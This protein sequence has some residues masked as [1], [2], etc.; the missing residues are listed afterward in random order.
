MVRRRAI[1]AIFLQIELS[2][3]T[4]ISLLTASCLGIKTSFTNEEGGEGER[5]QA[6]ND[7]V[8]CR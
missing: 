5:N 6:V 7:E 3:S 2:T 4:V 1:L 8:K